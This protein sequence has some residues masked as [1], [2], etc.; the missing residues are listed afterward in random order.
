MRLGSTVP[1]CGWYN[2]T[3]EKLVCVTNSQQLPLNSNTLPLV[4]DLPFGTFPF[5]PKEGERKL[6]VCLPFA[7]RD[8][9]SAAILSRHGTK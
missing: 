9:H 5:L 2:V 7:L 8:D 1:S 4:N 6:T 3:I